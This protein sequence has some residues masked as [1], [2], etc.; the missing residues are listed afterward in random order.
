MENWTGAKGTTGTS[1]N[2]YDP[3]DDSWNQIWVDNGGT[4]LILK[5]KWDGTNMTMGD[6]GG[7]QGN[8]NIKNSI[9]WTPNDDGSVTQ[10]WRLINNS[11]GSEK[12]IFEGLYRRKKE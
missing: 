10:I 8:E 11:N 2:Y 12:V 5:G 4:R 1:M 6:A 3:K 9:S 7:V